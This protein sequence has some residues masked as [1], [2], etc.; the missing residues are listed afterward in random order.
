MR[1]GAC[2]VAVIVLAGDQVSK[3]LV[4]ASH[5]VPSGGGGVVSVRLVRNTGASF[6]LGAGHPIVI[7]LTA[8]AVIAIV[9]VLL[10][11]T[12]SK[13]AALCLAAVLGGALGNLADR[14]FRAPGLGRGAVVDWI[15][16]AVYPATFNLADLAIR[17]GAIGAVVAL[18]G[19]R[20]RGASGRTRRPAAVDALPSQNEIDEPGRS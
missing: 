11:R 14:L 15:H 17:V 20:V 12:R 9:A 4:L 16:V 5:P 3:S 7:V 2:A 13:A 8:V 18:L 1:W 10:A 6:G 19:I